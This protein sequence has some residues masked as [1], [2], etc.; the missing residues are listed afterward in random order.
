MCNGVPSS[1]LCEAIGTV[2]S[3]CICVVMMCG[4]DWV[5]VVHFA[6]CLACV[7]LFLV[8][9]GHR[10]TSLTTG[11]LWTTSSLSATDAAKSA[12]CRGRQHQFSEVNI[13]FPA[14]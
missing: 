5:L 12:R 14:W 7:L 9:N 4:C 6:A 3:C 13:A 8:N 10:A 2:V 1:K 11:G